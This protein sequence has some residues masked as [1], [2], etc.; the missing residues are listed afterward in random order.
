MSEMGSS[1]THRF[2]PRLRGGGRRGRLSKQY[3]MRRRR[4]HGYGSLLRDRATHWLV[5]ASDQREHGN[6]SVLE[7]AKNG[8]IASVAVLPRND[9]G[10]RLS[11]R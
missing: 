7:G 6:L 3:P 4:T 8:G 1:P 5:I 10:R 11:N 9:A 2:A